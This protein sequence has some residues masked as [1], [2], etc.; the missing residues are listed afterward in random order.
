MKKYCILAFVAT[1][2]LVGCNSYLDVKP[3][4]FTIPELLNDYQLLIN[5]LSLIRA[6]PAY[7]D[8]LS[9]HV[10]AGDPVDV[11]KSTSFESLPTVKKRLY[12][13][14][15]GAI[16]EDGQY[17]PYWEA[18]YSHIF[19]YN[20]V[21]N[22]VLNA[23]DGKESERK[24]VWAEAKI[25]RAFEYLTLVNIY[26]KHYEPATASTDLGVPMVLSENINEPYE[27]VSV[28]KIYELVE[29]DLNDA[30][31]H[32][33]SSS[34]HKFQALKTVG[35]AFLSRMN[36]YKGNY[37]AALTNA[38]EAIK[39]NEYLEDYNQYTTK[40]KTTWGRV[41]LVGD[42]DVPFPDVRENK[43]TI[44][45][46]L[47]TSTYGAMNAEVYASASLLDTYKKSLPAGATDMR[48]K[49]FFCADSASFG[50]NVVR[51]PGR[52]LFAPY[53]E[54]N[55]GFNTPE[56]YLII[57]ECEA[58]QGSVDQAL[59]WLNKLRDKRIKNNVHV[60]GLSKEKAIEMVLDERRREI[61]YTAS[62]RLIDMKRLAI[63]KDLTG[64]VTHKLGD[65]SFS[66]PVSD[67]RLILPVPPKVLS[68]NPSIPQYER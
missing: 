15:H 45:G 9:D 11:N 13:F 60:A 3:K 29:A 1:L 7:P 49:L 17:D 42:E 4:G 53:V 23:I 39:L 14:E 38:K 18:A 25:G 57:A 33:A 61:P 67:N 8:Y 44:W 64:N 56:L 28:A 51:F 43:E 2:F 47:G 46:R 52:T 48:L 40:L 54:M 41:H 68:L 20:V 19:T 31:P 55:T 50:A 24:R 26:A 22:N 36:L 21:I 58:R 34:A 30:L 63:S 59:S 6:S 37:A 16:F 32:L 62:T 65:Q 10:Q 35:F 27:R 12:M 66:M 5:D